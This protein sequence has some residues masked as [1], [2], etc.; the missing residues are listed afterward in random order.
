MR[1]FLVVAT[2]CLLAVTGTQ[3]QVAFLYRFDHGILREFSEDRRPGTTHFFQFL[4]NSN[5]DIS[6]AVPASL[7]VAGLIRQDPAMK[8]NALYITES[9]AVSSLA[10]IALKYGVNR[11][12]PFTTDSL[13]TKASDGGSPSFPSGHTSEAFS[14]ATSLSIAYPHWYVIAPAYLWAS[15][16]A[17]SR[18]YLGVHYPTDVIAGAVVGSGSAWL[19]YKANQWLV[20]RRDQRHHPANP[21]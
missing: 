6:L 8:K 14:I 13:I 20:R 21:Y 2:T 17:F 9:F 12:R 11:P 7:F 4:S 3:A 16:V 5:N 1:K 10:T 15:S 18:L 19:T